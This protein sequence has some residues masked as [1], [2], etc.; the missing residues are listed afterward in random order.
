MKIIF[1]YK[2]PESC[3]DF[4]HYNIFSSKKIVKNTVLFYFG[5]I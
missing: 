2:Y 1:L 4:E 3:D 5:I